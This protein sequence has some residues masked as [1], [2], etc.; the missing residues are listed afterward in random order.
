[1]AE[2]APASTGGW[3]AIAQRAQDHRDASIAAVEPPLEGM[4]AELPLDVSKLPQDIL[5]EHEA[6]IT[7]SPPD[8]LVEFLARGQLTA[9]AVAKAFLRRAALAQ[10]LVCLHRQ[11]LRRQ[12]KR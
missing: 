8:E 10:K 7:E 5:N 1:M 11:L 3:R 2:S 9:T 6:W 4:P 12:K